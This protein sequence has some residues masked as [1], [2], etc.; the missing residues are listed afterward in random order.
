MESKNLTVL[1][2]VVEEGFGGGNLSVIDDYFYDDFIEHQFG[3]KG[4]KEG[5][6][7]SINSLHA[8][9]PDLVSRLHNFSESGDTVWG[10]FVA[11]GTHTGSFMNNPPTGKKFSIDI[12]DVA[13][14][15]DGKIIEHWGVPDRFAM[16]MQLGMLQPSK[17]PAV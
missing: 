5:L 8:A 17:E 13:R 2:K 6:K 1:R 11:T 16:I 10:H 9:F 12:I 3:L 7:K 15:R 14:F 4:G